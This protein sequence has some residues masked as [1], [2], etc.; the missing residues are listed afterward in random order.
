MMAKMGTSEYN[1]KIRRAIADRAAREEREAQEEADGTAERRSQAI[2]MADAECLVGEQAYRAST[3]CTIR[4]SQ[5]WE[6]LPQQH[7]GRRI[8]EAGLRNDLLGCQMETDG[9]LQDMMLLHH[10]LYG[11]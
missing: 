3:E 8:F 10:D 5:E 1:A 4:A 7:I 9:C 6:A 11:I 2:A